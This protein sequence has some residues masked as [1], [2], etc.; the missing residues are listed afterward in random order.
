MI[1]SSYLP[2]LLLTPLQERGLYNVG[3]ARNTA[4]LPCLLKCP[5]SHMFFFSPLFLLQALAE[6]G[7]PTLM[8]GNKETSLPIAHL[9]LL[10]RCYRLPCVSFFFFSFLF[11]SPDVL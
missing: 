10:S 5:Y 11:P 9:S 6:H 4:R 1:L 2:Y 3:G 8:I 7:I